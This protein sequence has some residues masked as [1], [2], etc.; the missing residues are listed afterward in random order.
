MAL[1]KVNTGT[2]DGEV[3]ALRWDWEVQVPEVGTSAFLIPKERVKSREERLVVLNEVARSVIEA[4]RG[5]HPESVFTCK[6]KPRGVRR[7]GTATE[8]PCPLNPGNSI[9]CLLGSG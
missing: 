7:G 5:V 1:F 3:C 9:A 2:R 6:G 4:C 8:D